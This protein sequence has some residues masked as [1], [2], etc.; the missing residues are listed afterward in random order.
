MKDQKHTPTPLRCGKRVYAGSFTGHMC[1]KPVFKD[2]FCKTHHPDSVKARQEKSDARY[3]AMHAPRIAFAERTRACLLACEGMPDPA[4]EIARLREAASKIMQRD[5]YRC[6]SC[7]HAIG[8]L[9]CC[10]DD[11]AVLPAID[12]HQGNAV[13]AARK[14][15]EEI[16]NSERDKLREVN[17]ELMTALQAAVDIAKDAHAYWDRDAD[18]KAGKLLIAL[19]GNAYGYSRKTD[20]I[21]D[22]IAKHSAP[23]SVEEKGK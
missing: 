11:D 14:R 4:A 9:V 20:F 12:A 16:G 13:Q 3:K 2:G 22:T 8:H 5:G 15:W 1:T 23:N 21:H 10:L 19:S 18:T 6:G 7:G 17:G